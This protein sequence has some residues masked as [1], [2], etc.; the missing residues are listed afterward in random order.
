MFLQYWFA[1][2]P[3]HVA[4][5]ENILRVLCRAPITV[6]MRERGGII[7]IAEYGQ[8]YGTNNPVRVLYHGY[9]HYEALEL[10]EDRIMSSRL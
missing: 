10:P 3:S 1:S 5:M 2:C 7:S 6:Y 8:E 9:G 4:S